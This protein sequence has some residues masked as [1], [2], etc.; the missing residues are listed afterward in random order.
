MPATERRAFTVAEFCD[1]YRLSKAQY[2][3][4]KKDKK[5]PVEAHVRG[6]VIISLAAAEKWLEERQ[7]EARSNV[8]RHLRRK[9]K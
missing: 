3:E 2:Y 9:K 5:G 4:L 6:R 8:K 1:A 7:A